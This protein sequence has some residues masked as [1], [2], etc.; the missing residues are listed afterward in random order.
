MSVM[1][2]FRGSLLTNSGTLFALTEK[3]T[4]LD[5]AG[6]LVDGPREAAYG[7]PYDD[8]T[9]IAKASD[10]L[11]IGDYDENKPGLHA[12]RHALY[13]ILVKIQRLVQTPDH[14]DSI[15]DIAGYARTYEK[16]LER[17]FPEPERPKIGYRD[18]NESVPSTPKDGDRAGKY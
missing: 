6:F 7:H 4:I 3:R 15:V 11:G 13:M 5:E 8:F 10:A 1:L 9:A 2:L 16:V 14:H 18:E 12:L 17:I